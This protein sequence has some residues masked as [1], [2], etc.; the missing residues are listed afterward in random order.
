M[1]QCVVCGL[2][3]GDKGANGI[4]QMLLGLGGSV[5]WGPDLFISPLS[6]PPFLTAFMRRPARTLSSMLSAL[7]WGWPSASQAPEEARL[8]GAFLSSG[9]KK[10]CGAFS[11]ATCTSW[12]LRESV[13]R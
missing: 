12:E 7:T 3:Q 10:E 13:Q 9:R 1:T 2:L 8:A 6:S 11:V 5:A 4:S